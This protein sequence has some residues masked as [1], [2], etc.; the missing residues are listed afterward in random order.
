MSYNNFSKLNQEGKIFEELAKQ[1]IWWTLLNEDKELY[2]DIRKGKYINVYYAGSSIAK[3]TYTKDFKASIHKKFL[4]G[5]FFNKSP[6]TELEVESLTAQKIVEIKS[7]VDAMLATA[8]KKA[9]IAE[10]VLLGKQIVECKDYIDSDFQFE[11]DKEI[12]KIKIDLTELANNKLSFVKVRDIAD[13]NLMSC[14]KGSDTPEIVTQVEQYKTFIEKY[15]DELKV[16]YDT[17]I[18][19]KQSLCIIP[20]GSMTFTVNKEPKLLIVNTYLKSSEARKKR[21]EEI[22]TTLKKHNVNFEIK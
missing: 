2:F 9:P 13:K 14:N 7:R 5:R 20:E 8:D 4:D 11:R 15:T 19:M 21:I 18:E 10:K 1:P 12:G 3:I 17:L 6:Y 16:Y 22:K